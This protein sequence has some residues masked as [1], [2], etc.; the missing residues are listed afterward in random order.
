[1]L[2]DKKRDIKREAKRVEGERKSKK[3]EEKES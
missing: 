1:M 3:R 2:E